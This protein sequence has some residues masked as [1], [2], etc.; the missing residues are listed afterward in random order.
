MAAGGENAGGVH[1]RGMGQIS[2]IVIKLVR[3]NVFI[4]KVCNRNNV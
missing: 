1:G 3:E 2:Q 4:N